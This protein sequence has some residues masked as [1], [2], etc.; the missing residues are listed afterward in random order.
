MLNLDEYVKSIKT[1][2]ITVGGK[3]YTAK[4]LTLKQLLD[5][6]RVYNEAGEDSLEPVT[7]LFN[8]VGY[9]AEE[10]LQLPLEAIIQVQTELFL[11]IQEQAQKLEQN[12]KKI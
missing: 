2:Q 11:S 8:T 6:Q 10:L 4:P 3:E 12:A 9:P 5:I 7:L 1:H